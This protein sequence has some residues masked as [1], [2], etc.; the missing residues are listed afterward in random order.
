MHGKLRDISWRKLF[1]NTFTF[2]K[3]IYAKEESVCAYD[4]PSLTL[5]FLWISPH[6]I[7]LS[8]NLFI[9]KITLFCEYIKAKRIVRFRKIRKCPSGN[10]YA[11][12]H[13]IVTEIGQKLIGC[14]YCATTH[15]KQTA[16]ISETVIIDNIMWFHSKGKLEVDKLSYSYPPII[17]S[18][19][20][21]NRIEQ[22]IR[23][24]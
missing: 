10:G 15:F 16:T 18:P 13:A 7:W 11:I 19:K 3:L 14:S 8:D 2:K 24:L 1:L 9:N 20:N 23:I 21:L 17:K 4:W 22:R 6:V 5:F 12:Y